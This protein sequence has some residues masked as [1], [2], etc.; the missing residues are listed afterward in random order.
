MAGLL[1][2]LGPED[3]GIVELFPEF[4]P[5]NIT[6][7]NLLGQSEGLKFYAVGLYIK[8]LGICIFGIIISKRIFLT[9]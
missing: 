5:L 2:I 6:N 7:A 1:N 3:K 9:F 8:L 4:R